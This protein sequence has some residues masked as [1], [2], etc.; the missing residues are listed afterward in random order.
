VT[1]YPQTDRPIRGA[2]AEHRTCLASVQVGRPLQG[3][4]CSRRCAT[5]WS[6]RP[7]PNR[8]L[9]PWPGTISA[10]TGGQSEAELVDV[11][12]RAKRPDR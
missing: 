7:E 9:L 6:F 8:I 5:T 10:Q 2:A 11:V 4:N 1:R 3:T 12:L